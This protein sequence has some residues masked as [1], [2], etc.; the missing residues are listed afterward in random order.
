MLFNYVFAIFI[1]TKCFY[2]HDIY[3][4]ALIEVMGAQLRIY[5]VSGKFRLE[6][7]QENS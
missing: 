6:A 4:I 3:F 7:T 1:V 5:F 2:F